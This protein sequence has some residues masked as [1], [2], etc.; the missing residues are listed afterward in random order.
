MTASC[1]GWRGPHQG[2]KPSGEVGQA[3]GHAPPEPKDGANAIQGGLY[4]KTQQGSQSA[5]H[6]INRVGYHVGE[7]VG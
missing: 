4:S 2:P 1:H 7:C 6:H 5:P 3:G